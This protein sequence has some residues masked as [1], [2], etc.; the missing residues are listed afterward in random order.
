MC[1]LDFKKRHESR[2][3]KRKRTSG[4]KEDKT[5]YWWGVRDMIKLYCIHE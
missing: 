5:R 4:R 2:K 1:N 3:G